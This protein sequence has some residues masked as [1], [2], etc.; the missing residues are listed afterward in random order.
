MYIQCIYMRIKMS[1]ACTYVRI[2][3]PFYFCVIC[4][5]G[6]G[7]TYLVVT[8]AMTECASERLVIEVRQHDE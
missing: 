3:T 8:E 4:L 5:A 6:R 1:H 2:H 7:L